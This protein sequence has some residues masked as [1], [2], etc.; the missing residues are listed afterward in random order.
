MLRSDRSEAAR[1]TR[2][3]RPICPDYDRPAPARLVRGR[4]GVCS[5]VGTG[6]D[7]AAGGGRIS[8]R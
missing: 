7:G 4:V 3:N 1:R 8:P 5:G 6:R 2:S